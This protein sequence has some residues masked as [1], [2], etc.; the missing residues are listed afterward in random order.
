MVELKTDM[1]TG[2][3]AQKEDTAQIPKLFSAFSAAV[4]SDLSGPK[5]FLNLS[6]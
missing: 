5:L 1:Y 2:I 6:R 3:R 4:L